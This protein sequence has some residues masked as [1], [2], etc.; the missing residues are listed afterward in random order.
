MPLK[1][2]SSLL[3]VKLIYLRGNS[4]K[5]SIKQSISLS[6]AMFNAKTA[7]KHTLILDYFLLIQ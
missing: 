7:H 6:S 3:K 4:Q 2:N 5:M 1:K